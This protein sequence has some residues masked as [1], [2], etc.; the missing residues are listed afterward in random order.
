MDANRAARQARNR[1][2]YYEEI[3]EGG[4]GHEQHCSN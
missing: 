1:D 2:R 4:A 3:E